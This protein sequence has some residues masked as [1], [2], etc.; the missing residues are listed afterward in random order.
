MA[1]ELRRRMS[2]GMALATSS[3]EA[4]TLVASTCVDVCRSDPVR[5]PKKKEEVNKYHKNN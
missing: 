5:T 4:T 2:G 3:A 1:R